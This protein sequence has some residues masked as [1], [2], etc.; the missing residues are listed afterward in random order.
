MSLSPVAD[1]S[2]VLIDGPWRHEFVSA[3]GTR[4]HVAISDPTAVSLTTAAAG[5]GARGAENLGANTGA[6]PVAAAGAPKTP[7]VIQAPLV[8][9]LHTFG[10]FWWAWR[11]QMEAL[12]LA[13]FR[14]AAMDLRGVGASDKPPHGYDV[15]TR[16]RDVAGV[17]RSLGHDGAV[18]VGLGTGGEV[19]WAMGALQPSV[20]RAVAALS[21]VHPARLHASLRQV[22]TRE[23]R[24]WLLSAQWPSIPE[25][26]LMETDSLARFMALGASKPFSSDELD[27]YSTAM[28]IPFAAHTSLEAIR[29]TVRTASPR[30]DGMRYRTGV[31]RLI[32]IPALQIAGSKDGY[33]RRQDVDADSSAF[34]RDLQFEVLDGVGH[35]LPEEAPEQ[36]NELLLDWLRRLP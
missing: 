14:V 18:V 31:R 12:G 29:W 11:H 5:E 32:T 3:N 30:P 23:A 35:Y 36:V 8:V 24:S 13:G 28:K 15:P 33:L 22:L 7:S 21:S 17:I 6:D 16:T 4:F 27:L 9:L 1:Y 34:A 10:Q 26:R 25:K 20:T 2:A 19:A